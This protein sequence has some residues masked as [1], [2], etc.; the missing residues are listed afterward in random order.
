MSS[1]QLT[2]TAVLDRLRELEASKQSIE[3]EQLSL[4][5]QVEA[6]G[7]AFDLGAKN[8]AVLLRDALKIGARDAASRV[9]LAA[10]VTPRR[11]LTGDT[12]EAAH[13]QTAAALAE[14]AIST[15][16]AATVV[17][18]TDKIDDLLADQSAPLYRDARCS[19]SPVTTTPTCWPASPTACTPGSIRTGRFVTSRP[20]TGAAACRCA[21]VRTGQRRSP[22]N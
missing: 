4:I 11:T 19:T 20:R 8:T 13:P 10:A 1:L 3:V 5:A 21:G 22:A 16:A 7:L 6:E 9:K 2:G 12:V 17:A 18:M 15:R 14:G